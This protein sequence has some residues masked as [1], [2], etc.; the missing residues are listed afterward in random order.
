M[1]RKEVPYTKRSRNRIDLRTK[2]LWELFARSPDG[3]I[4]A[5]NGSS[6]EGMAGRH[7]AQEVI[8]DVCLPRHGG[9]G[10][11]RRGRRRN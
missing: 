7:R 5:N 8:V 4:E 6:S 1:C 10:K 11:G 3:S 9:K 2:Y